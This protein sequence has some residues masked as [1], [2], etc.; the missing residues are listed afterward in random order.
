MA[1]DNRIEPADAG[2]RGHG[3]HADKPSQIP[4]PGIK[5]ILARVWQNILKKN[6]SLIA[7][8]VTYYML[9]ALFPALATLVSIYGLVADPA[10]VARTLNAL[11]RVIPASSQQ[12]IAAELTHLTSASNTALSA[13]AI[14]GLIISLGTASFGVSGM[15]S[16]LN[17]T[18]DQDDNRSLF[19]FY[20]IT[21]ILTIG[22]II[23]GVITLV[24]VALLPAI[25]IHIDAD[26]TTKWIALIVE[27]PL[28]MAFVMATLMVLYRYAP[29]REEARWEWITPGA[30]IATLLWVVVSLLFTIYVAHFNNYNATYGA[31]GAVAVLLTWLWLSSYIVL[32]GAEINA[33]AERQTRRDSTTGPPEPMGE[34]GATVADTLGKTRGER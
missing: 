8:G 14:I 15:I 2:V 3:R 30:V 20:L 1:Q 29:D 19:K 22:M 13:G 34:R 18:Y 6:L 33:E 10:Q 21:L 26:A 7:G 23:S 4:T 27:W 25:L 32:L 31:L 12:L 17:I 9:L 28:L 5:D 24:L 16:A 11:S